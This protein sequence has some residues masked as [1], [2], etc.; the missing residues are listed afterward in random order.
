MKKEIQTLSLHELQEMTSNVI[1]QALPDHYWVV[2]EISEMNENKSGHCYLELVEKDSLN[3]KIVA[4]ARATIWSFTYRLLKSYFEMS[5]GH[6]FQ[7]GIKALF[8]LH[9]EFHTVYGHSLNIVEIDPAYSLGDMARKRSETIEKLKSEGIFEMNKELI[10]PLVPQRI[11]VIS[12]ETAAGFGD[13]IDQL[14]QN[15]YGYVFEIQLFSAIVQGDVAEKSVILALEKIHEH[16]EDFDIIVIIRG[17]GSKADLA[18]FDQYDLTAHIAQFPIPILTGIGHER[19]Q[20]V[21]DMVAFHACKTPTAVAE[22][23]IAQ[24][25][26]FENT[27]NNYADYLNE[28]LRIEFQIQSSRLEKTISKLQPLLKNF[29]QEKKHQMEIL[30]TNIYPILQAKLKDES[31]KANKFETTLKKNLL[32]LLKIQNIKFSN[33]SIL[34]KK[35]FEHTLQHNHHQIDL[36]IE[37]TKQIDPQE[38]LKKGYSLTYKKGKL[39]NSLS[40]LEIGDSIETRLHNGSIESEVKNLIS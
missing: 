3:K 14:Q 25:N 31:F 17:G 1:Q 23:I 6:R 12:S 10:F 36:F 7:N 33:Q 4:K 13:F 15:E 5:T 40:E 9:V 32:Y 11:A 8:K 35:A 22:Y 16:L 28:K 29:I 2:A 39:I 18:C 30:S 34:L 27:I 20:S 37:K 19:D 24:V 26:D 21:A 38:V